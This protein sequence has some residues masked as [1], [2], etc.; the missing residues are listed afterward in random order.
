MRTKHRSNLKP[1]LEI[2]ICMQDQYLSATSNVSLT[3]H[4]HKTL[5]LCSDVIYEL[6][7]KLV[8]LQWEIGTPQI[9]YRI[10]NSSNIKNQ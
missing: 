10:N 8:S 1:E 9:R 5:K 7:H 6:G 2:F 4:S 3:Q